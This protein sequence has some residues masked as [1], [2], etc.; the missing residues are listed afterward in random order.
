M[1]RIS[2]SIGTNPDQ[3]R[4][5]RLRTNSARWRRCVFSAGRTVA[6]SASPADRTRERNRTAREPDKFGWP[7]D[8][9]PAPWYERL[10]YLQGT[11]SWQFWRFTERRFDE[12]ALQ[13]LRSTMSIRRAGHTIAGNASTSSPVTLRNRRG[14]DPAGGLV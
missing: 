4:A 9:R 3:L 10:Q 13:T 7:G 6:S 12:E 2:S 14:A 11:G 8:A 1:A 5:N